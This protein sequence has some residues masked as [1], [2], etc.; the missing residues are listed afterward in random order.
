M[1]FRMSE[2]KNLT[3]SE[4]PMVSCPNT[5]END[6]TNATAGRFLFHDEKCSP[7]NEFD[8]NFDSLPNYKYTHSWGIP[9]MWWMYPSSSNYR[10]NHI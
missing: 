4:G 9:A 1:M 8:P 7:D 3:I 10:D 2:N 6:P 5:N